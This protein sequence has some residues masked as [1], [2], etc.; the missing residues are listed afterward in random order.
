MREDTRPGGGR[1]A[2]TLVKHGHAPPPRRAVR[3]PW[4]SRCVLWIV[5]RVGEQR[6]GGKTQDRK[7]VRNDTEGLRGS[8]KR[9]SGE[10]RSREREKFRISSQDRSRLSTHDT[11][12]MWQRKNVG[13]SALQVRTPFLE[14]SP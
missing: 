8:R 1:C 6:Q 5:T 11:T 2:A 4:E 9:Q 12:C 7:D 13:R 14:S 3:R 10:G